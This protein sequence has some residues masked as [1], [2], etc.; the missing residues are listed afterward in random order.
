VVIGDSVNA[1]PVT[2]AA[3]KAVANRTYAWLF[4]IEVVCTDMEE[5]RRRV[6]TRASD[7]PGHKLPTWEQVQSREYEPWSEV[8]LVIDTG[9]NTVEESVSI[10]VD[11]LEKA[12]SAGV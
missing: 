7:I 2:R 6:E 5:H 11:A 9:T 4:E 3:W 10:T 12:R 8:D 1:L